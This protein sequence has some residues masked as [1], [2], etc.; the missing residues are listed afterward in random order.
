MMLLGITSVIMLAAIVA[1][2]YLDLIEMRQK[3]AHNTQADL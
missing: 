1:G 2:N 3:Q